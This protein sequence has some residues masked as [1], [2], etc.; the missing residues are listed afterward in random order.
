MTTLTFLGTG[1]YLAQGR[2]WNS[3][4]VD[5]TVLVEPSPSCLPQLRRAGLRASAVEHVLISHFHPD[6]TFGWPFLVLELIEDARPADR[7]LHV[8]GPPGV[9]AYLG[10]MMRLG[11]VAHL[12]D[13]L[14]ARSDI[15]YVEVD[16]TWQEVGGLRLR[17]VEV[18]HVDDLECFGFLLDRGDAMVGYSGDTT[19]CAGVDELAAAADVLV[20]ECNGT[21]R[22]HNHMDVGSVR[23][24]HERFPDTRIVLTHV[25][26]DV[27]AP[28]GVELPADLDVLEL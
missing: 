20:L 14:E 2:W 22:A 3:F 9:R 18:V 8:I 13:E 12:V 26:D 16:R 11:S 24:L 5:G 28:D 4:V 10:E 17:A 27:V 7:P 15:R 6:H 23:S 25:G 21:H 1:N 19:A